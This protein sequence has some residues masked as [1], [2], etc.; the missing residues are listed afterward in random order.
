[1]SRFD[2]LIEKV[3]A[4]EFAEIPFRHL[5]I[6]D[7]LKEEDFQQIIT[8]K[9]V[10][11]SG[12][13][14][15]ELHE[16]LTT[17]EYKHQSHPGTFQ[18]IGKYRK[19]RDGNRLN[20]DLVQGAQGVDSVEGGGL[21]Y[22]LNSESPLI[23]DLAQIFSSAA[24]VETIRAKFE[25]DDDAIR[26]DCGLQKYLT[27]YEIS[28]HPDTREKALTWMLNLNPDPESE[29]ATYHTH[30][31]RFKKEY[32]YMHSLWGSIPKLQRTWVPWDWCDT[33]FLQTDNNSITIFS[34]GNYSL[35]AVKANYDDLKHQR[36][37]L[38]GNYWYETPRAELTMFNFKD[39]QIESSFE[40]RQAR[41]DSLFGKI[42][43]KVKSHISKSLG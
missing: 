6:R 18:S 2:Y 1:M 7:F 41:Y 8:S 34:P 36:T 42:R 19:F 10:A 21:T 4:A 25:L 23:K 28:P 26:I 13:N 37:Q 14:F 12:R 35:H 39:F 29:S 31:L 27:G 17:A 16:K 30:F 20:V 38:Y 11:I 40:K 5:Y 22:R 33:E 9:E 3:S 32:Q 15:D 43:R 24:M